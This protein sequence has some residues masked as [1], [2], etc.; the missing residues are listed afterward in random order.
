MTKLRLRMEDL[1]VESFDSS[2]ARPQ[3]G[4]VMGQETWYPTE[5]TCQGQYTC[6]E[7]CPQTCWETCDATCPWNHT[8]WET[9]GLTCDDPTCLTCEGNTCVNCPTAEFTCGC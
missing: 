1:A 9:C 2:P 7:S 6:V 3:R 8:C 4:T 5:C